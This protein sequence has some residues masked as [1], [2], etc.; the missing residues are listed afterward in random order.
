MMSEVAVK[1]YK[2]HREQIS[3]PKLLKFVE[4]KLVTSR[5]IKLETLKDLEKKINSAFMVCQ[6]EKIVQQPILKP[7]MPTSP[8][9][10]LH[11]NREQETKFS[12]KQPH[13]SVSIQKSKGKS[14]L[15]P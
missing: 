8:S 4:R 14:N 6:T 10:P 1:L 2:H 15:A 12:F 5:D 9:P 7:S 13:Y 3:L 11:S